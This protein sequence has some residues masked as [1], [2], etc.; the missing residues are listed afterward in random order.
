MYK[1]RFKN[2]YDMHDNIKGALDIVSGP[3]TIDPTIVTA[4]SRTF[5]LLAILKRTEGGSWQLLKDSHGLPLKTGDINVPG[6]AG[7]QNALVIM[8][9]VQSG[10]GTGTFKGIDVCT[11]AMPQDISFVVTG[12]DDVD[13]QIE[14]TNLP[15]VIAAATPPAAW[16][17]GVHV[18]TYNAA[19]QT[20]ATKTITLK[21]DAQM[22]GNLAS[23]ISLFNG[24]TVPTAPHQ[25]SYGFQ[26]NNIY[27][28][29]YDIP[30]TKQPD[31]GKVITEAAYMW[32][33]AGPKVDADGFG[34]VNGHIIHVPG[35][36]PLAT[37]IAPYHR[38]I[39]TQWRNLNAAFVKLNAFSQQHLKELNA[40]R[41][42]ARIDVGHVAFDKNVLADVVAEKVIAK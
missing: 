31:L 10:P 40:I 13:V 36:N 11:F 35:N 18:D 14:S 30:P 9:Y 1:F 21:S 16:S 4:D 38:E 22:G 2:L 28:V 26:E 33:S 5:S 37:E 27:L 8:L 29:C 17:G 42:A 34:I 6:G 24:A 7:A 32:V 41:N 39:M 20:S 3:E 25:I 12:D 15:V 19:V 23:V